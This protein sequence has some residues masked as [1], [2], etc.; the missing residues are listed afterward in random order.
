MSPEKIERLLTDPNW[1]A[2]LLAM[3]NSNGMLNA[4]QIER[5]LTDESHY[6]RCG[7]ANRDD[8]TPTPFQIERG[9]RDENEFVRLVFE[10]RRSEWLEV[11]QVKA[12]R[13]RFQADK[14]KKTR[15]T[16]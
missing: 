12:L 5:G 15:K 13:E 8:Y 16:L 2:R 1:K 4:F 3:K 6:V 10:E 11:N 14:I 9:L 7:F